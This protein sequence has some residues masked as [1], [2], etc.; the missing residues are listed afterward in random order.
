MKTKRVFSFKRCMICE[1]VLTE[2]LKEAL[3]QTQVSHYVQNATE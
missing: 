2:N 3:K 1:R